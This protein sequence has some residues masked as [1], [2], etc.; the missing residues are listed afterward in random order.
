MDMRIMAKTTE[1][2]RIERGIRQSEVGSKIYALSPLEPVTSDNLNG[3]EKTR[4][5][6]RE[7]RGAKRN[8]R[9]PSSCCVSLTSRRC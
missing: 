6:K 4:G 8:G 9:R 1:G 7:K 5:E 2:Y 3:I